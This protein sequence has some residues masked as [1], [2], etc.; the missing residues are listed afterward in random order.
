MCG[1]PY[2][3]AANLGQWKC[4]YH[5]GRVIDEEWSCCGRRPMVVGCRAADHARTTR[6]GRPPVV[7]RVPA[8]VEAAAPLHESIVSGNVPGGWPVVEVRNPADVQT[9]AEEAYAD[10]ERHNVKMVL[11]CDA[12]TMPAMP[13]SG[14]S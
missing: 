13:L 7:S 5:P 6:S 8:F 11:R 9:A 12:Y 3:E 2:T 4:F 1:N 14:G 10:W